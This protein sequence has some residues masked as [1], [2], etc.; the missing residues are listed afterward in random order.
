[1]GKKKE[2]KK[3]KKKDNGSPA[4]RGSIPLHKDTQGDLRELTIA[5]NDILTRRDIIIRENIRAAG[6]ATTERG[7]EGNYKISKDFTMLEKIDG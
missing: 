7:K 2:C 1:M 3:T 6:K 4:K 5:A